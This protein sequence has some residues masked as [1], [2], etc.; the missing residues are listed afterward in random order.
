[1]LDSAGRRSDATEVLTALNYVD[2]LNADQHA[3]L[4]ERLLAAGAAPDSLREFQVML[5]LDSHDPAPANF[6]LARAYAA[7]GDKPA[8][9]HRLLDALASAPHY[10]PAQDLLL[11][12]IEERSK[13]E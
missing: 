10:K 6:G 7:L 1:L 3:Q 8:S 12:M 13:N 9:R 11:Q 2:P 4:G 5:A